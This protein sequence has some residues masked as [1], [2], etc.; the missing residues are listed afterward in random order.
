MF[1]KF[2]FLIL[3]ILSMAEGFI[4]SQTSADF[5]LDRVIRA[6][7]F[8]MQVESID[9]NAIHCVGTGTIVT[10]SG[11]I[12]ANAH[13]TTSNRTCQG[14]SIVIALNTGI[15]T[16]PIAQYRA[17]IVQVDEGLDIAVLQI[18]SDLGG[19]NIQQESLALPFVEMADSD[20]VDL[21]DTLVSAGYP[22][23]EGEAVTT[24]RGNVS[25]FITE[26]GADPSWFKFEV[27][28]DQSRITGT[29]TGG[30]TYNQN[31]QLI[32]VP[33]TVPVVSSFSDINCVR[34][35]DTNGDNRVNNNDICVPIGG[36]INTLRPSNYI[37][38]LLRSASLGLNVE[39]ITSD[40]VPSSIIDNPAFSN[41]IFATS[42]N[43][44]MPTRVVNSLPANPTSL[45][46]FFDYVN[47]SS[48]D[49][50]EL[51]IETDGV[52]NPIFSLP[53]VRW[54]GGEQGLWYIGSTEQAWTSG[55]YEFTLFINGIVAG[56]NR[57]IVGAILDDNPSF[58]NVFFTLDEDGG[59]FGN[60]F[61][62]PTGN[63]VTARFVYQNLRPD[64]IWTEVWYFNGVEITR[65]ENEWL[66]QDGSQGT[67][68]LTLQIGEGGF[69]PGR[70][71]LELYILNN[72]RN[73]LAAK[74]D[75]VVAG[76]R[77]GA[78]A[79]IFSNL[80]LVT[81]TN[82]DEAIN[83]ASL[84]SYPSTISNLFAVFDW[85]QLAPGILWTMQWYVDD[86]LFYED[87]VP[88]GNLETG[89]NFITRLSANDNL[90]DGTY[91]MELR[92]N[93]Q[94]LVSEE[95]Q[96]GIGQLP[97]DRFAQTDGIQ[98][99]GQLVDAETREGL[100]GITVIIITEEYSVGDFVWD[101]DQVYSVAITD[102][103]GNFQIDRLLEYDVQ[104]SVIISTRGY[105]QASA[106][107]VIVTP[108]TDNPLN[109][110]IPMTRG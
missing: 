15:D 22:G 71:R 69:Q 7:V 106:D 56:N 107:G 36:E 87:I 34:I 80:R 70:Y 46:L 52:I 4:Q 90:P 49:V 14:H 23:I 97:I 109:I 105:L 40:V 110:L 76:A 47:M 28:A 84:E 44:N 26:P 3:L 94:L 95:V 18:T 86:E 11:L 20:A 99:Q 17:E 83:S 27:R 66:A 32:G 98:L 12:I 92:I 33:T 81:A 13:N 45:Y 64:I 9:D 35:Q 88:W 54:N 68:P 42:V 19:R 85:E 41:L 25:G 67:Y 38:P 61:V 60:V 43:E 104:Y 24:I 75:F 37:R 2:I 63:S 62:L 29:M 100:S 101:Q 91:R 31:G 74:A 5:D 65:S 103:N 10:R 59:A 1:Y 21:D 55:T 102:R 77:D 50:Y 58:R 51:R 30:G 108:E 6:T 48:E 82:A 96:I 57:I 79:R 73:A 39:K 53:P 78:I 8:V 89:R 16:Q 93:T 72:G